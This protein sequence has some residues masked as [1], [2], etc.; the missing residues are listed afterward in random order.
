[1]VKQQKI[2]YVKFTIWTYNKQ[3]NE[4]TTILSP[5]YVYVYVNTHAPYIIKIIEWVGMSIFVSINNH[6]LND[7]FPFSAALLCRDRDRTSYAP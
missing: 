2:S 7:P 5:M 4:T 1:M 3:L 6:E